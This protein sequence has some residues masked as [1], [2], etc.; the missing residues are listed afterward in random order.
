MR[1]RR[2]VPEVQQPDAESGPQV[3]DSLTKRQGR[4]LQSCRGGGEPAMLCD[5]PE[6]EQFIEE[7]SL[8]V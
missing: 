7:L 2:G 6:G 4:D 1:R 3:A 8:A 5:L